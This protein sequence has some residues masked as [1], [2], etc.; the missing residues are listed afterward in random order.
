[1]RPEACETELLRRLAAMPFLD[2]LEM[3][4]VSGRSRGAV[5][6]AVRKLESGRLVDS[7]PPRL[8]D[9]C[10]DTALLPHRRRAAPAGE[11]RGHDGRR[12]ARQVPRLRKGAARPHGE[13]RLSS[14]RL[15]P[16]HRNLQRRIPNALPLVPGLAHGRRHDAAGRENRRRPSGRGSPPAGLPSP[17]A[18]GGCAKNSGLAPSSCSC[19]TRCGSD[20]HAGSWPERP[21][22]PSSRWSARPPAPEPTPPSGVR[23][24]DRRSSTSGPHCRT[25]GGAEHGR[26]RSLRRR[27]SCPVRL[28]SEGRSRKSPAGCCPPSSSPPRSAHSTCSRTGRG[29][30]PPTWESCWE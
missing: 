13:T 1:M 21:P 29:S 11:R 22:S 26:P 6:E 14:R 23:R 18:C 19:P 12:A 2:R 9:H 17:S 27:S 25:R 7:V 24:Q 16:R 28:R 5:Y 8:A 15:P 4:A 30:R 20:T 10:P 3:A